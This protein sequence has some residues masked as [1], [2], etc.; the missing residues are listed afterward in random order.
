MKAYFFLLLFMLFTFSAYSQIGAVIGRN[1]S[2]KNEMPTYKRNIPPNHLLAQQITRYCKNDLE[3]AK[4]IFTWVATTISYDNELRNDPHLQK[5]YYTSEANVIRK[6]L[7]RKKAL[8]GGYAFLYKELCKQAGIESEV[9]HG[10]SKK[11][12]TIS[13]KKKQVDHTWNVVKINNKWYPLD[14]TMAVS[15]GSNKQPDMYWFM[16]NPEYFIKTH[17]PENARWALVAKPFSKAE[18]EKLPS[19]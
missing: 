13:N 12:Y 5:Q 1:P 7:E 2:P 18:F 11:Y 15:H 3:K 8:C 19:L 9:V 4:A 14:L 17:Y 10:Y 16:T 6:T